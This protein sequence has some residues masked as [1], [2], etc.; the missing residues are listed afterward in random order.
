VAWQDVALHLGRGA[1][2]GGA[3]GEGGIIIFNYY[4]NVDI[5]AGAA[6]GVGGGGGHRRGTGALQA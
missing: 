5:N 4:S 6:G 1:G 2:E 3:E